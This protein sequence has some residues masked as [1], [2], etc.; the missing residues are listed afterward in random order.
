[1]MAMPEINLAFFYRSFQHVSQSTTAVDHPPPLPSSWLGIQWKYMYGR[2]GTA[3]L[4]A[5][6][7]GRSQGAT[8]W[9]NYSRLTIYRS[10]Q[11]GRHSVICTHVHAY[12]KG[13]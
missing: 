1:M 4:D 7:N 12:I 9:F 8:K 13:S 6:W 5:D 2:Y 3:A 10:V 11:L